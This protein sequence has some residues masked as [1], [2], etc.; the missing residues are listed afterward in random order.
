MKKALLLLLP[1]L[2]I[3]GISCDSRY[4]GDPPVP[5]ELTV[6][7]TDD[8]IL[9]AEG[10]S[11]TLTVTS[12]TAILA[13]SDQQWCKVTQG[14]GTITISADALAGEA[15]PAAVVSITAGMFEKDL[16]TVTINV[17][18]ESFVAQNSMVLEV[19]TIGQTTAVVK[20]TPSNN[21]FPYTSGV[22][23][24]K[25]INDNY[26]GSVATYL[27]SFIAEAILNFESVEVV[28]SAISY[29]GNTEVAAQYLLPNT[30]YYAFA[31]EI[32]EQCELVSEV[33][34]LEFKTLAAT[35]GPDLSIIGTTTDY[36]DGDDAAE[37][38]VDY[39][40]FAGKA[41]LFCDFAVG[42]DATGWFYDISL[43]SDALVALSDEQIIEELVKGEMQGVSL[44]DLLTLDILE[45]DVE[46]TLL[47][48][49]QDDAVNRG[50]VYR[51]NFTLVREGAGDISVILGA[52]ALA[53][54]LD[55]L[56][57]K[58]K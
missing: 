56:R 15:G 55:I 58:M 6:T 34:S 14:E 10:G 11:K 44:V 22:V 52:P 49:A 9:P 19:G 41:M 47:A 26:G 50:T 33:Q 23:Q 54:K 35:S 20:V 25:D 30:E 51:H 17:S 45:W 7:P 46:Y 18:Q 57:A 53:P 27:E 2:L 37:I 31:V 5:T 24:V 40:V 36:Y 1:L 16:R 21:E 12:N 4:E 13:E 29:K 32:N 3:L 42:A 48:V 8:I 43:S 39:S 28:Y 38:N